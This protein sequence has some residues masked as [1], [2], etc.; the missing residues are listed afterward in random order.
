MPYSLL[1]IFLSFFAS[2]PEPARVPKNIILLIGDGMGLTQITAAMYQH[3]DSLSITSFP[4]TGIVTTHS[5]RERVT[6]SAAG[7]T[8]IACGCKT[9]NGALGIDDDKKPCASILELAHKAGL[10]T[11]M[12]VTSSLT[13]ATPAAFVAHLDSR[14]MVEPIAAAF[15]QTPV[16]LLIGGGMKYFTRRA[17]GRD[18]RAELRA[19]GYRV[20]SFEDGAFAGLPPDA[21]QPFIYFSALEEPP[22]VSHGR[23]NLLPSATRQ[24]LPFL[25][26]RS[27]KGFFLM[28]EGSQIDWAC[29]ANKGQELLAEMFDFDAAVGEAL[30]FARDN[31]E[32]L[33]LVTADHETGGLAI[34]MGSSR[35]SLE[36]A[37]TT[38]QHT[39]TLVPVFAYGPGAELFHGVLDNT[40]LFRKM[41]LLLGLKN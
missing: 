18:L 14:T 20:Q 6:D 36:L 8:A 3:G 7:A 17:D 4:V 11:G 27:Q 5:S 29:H 30:H 10:A 37:F 28:I 9:R 38:T 1:F 22:Y 21:A 24:A 12:V 35:D 40:D 33:V 25:Q 15:L 16:D 23:G 26:K 31:G 13:H 41:Q 19:Q 34:D 2:R 39:A 32:T